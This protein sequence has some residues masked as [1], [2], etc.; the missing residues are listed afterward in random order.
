MLTIVLLAASLSVGRAFIN[1][2]RVDRGFAVNGLVT[3]NVSL[4][5]TARGLDGQ[6][7]IYFEEA[8]A[9]VRR[10]PGVQSASATDSLPLY[11]TSFVGGPFGLD[12]RSAKENSMIV[13]V[14]SDYFRTMG[15]HILY[16]REFNMREI[17]ADAK[18]VVVNELFASQFGQPSDALGHEVTTR[19]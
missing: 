18:V 1:L 2:M 12:G 8:L 7:L 17:R 9:R 13:P 5:G 6:P 3:V 10:L 19:G 16:G 11:A 14:L 4:D 15:G